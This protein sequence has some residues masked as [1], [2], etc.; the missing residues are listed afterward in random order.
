MKVASSIGSISF[1][2]KVS[3]FCFDLRSDCTARLPRRHHEG[4]KI[5]LTSMGVMRIWDCE[6]ILGGMTTLSIS[7]PEDRRFF[8]VALGEERGDGPEGDENVL[9]NE[10]VERSGDPMGDEVGKC[11]VVAFVSAEN[12]PPIAEKTRRVRLARRRPMDKVGEINSP[13]VL[14]VAS[15]GVAD[16]IDADESVA[17][18]DI[19]ESDGREDHV[20]LRVIDGFN[21][22]RV[23]IL[24]IPTCFFASILS[25]AEETNLTELIEVDADGVD[26]NGC[27]DDERVKKRLDFPANADDFAVDCEDDKDLASESAG[28][29]VTYRRSSGIDK[30]S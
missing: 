14:G 11:V 17:S 6:I 29:I 19:D 4:V 24:A 1:P 28:L 21:R 7:N 25:L 27:C 26:D 22:C 18:L 8:G 16:D 13:T 2:T 20:D 15:I 30:N 23:P 12:A 3:S 10:F 5:S 9:R